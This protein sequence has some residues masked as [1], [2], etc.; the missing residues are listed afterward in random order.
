MIFDGRKQIDKPDVVAPGVQVWS[1]IPS[2][3]TGSA[4]YAYLDGTSMA[5]PHVS[6]VAALLMAACPGASAVQIRDVL[7]Q[8]AF[9]PTKYRPDNRYGYGMIQPIEALKALRSNT[10]DSLQANDSTVHA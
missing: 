1:S 2:I 10:N 3:R 8:T 6:G 9:H 7:K 4:S 5:A